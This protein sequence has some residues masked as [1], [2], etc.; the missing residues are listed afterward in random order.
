[1]S[2]AHTQHR[3]IGRLGTHKLFSGNQPLLNQQLRQCVGLRETGDEK[4][5]QCDRLSI[6]FCHCAS[7][8]DHFIRSHQHVGRD[9]QADLL[10][11]LQVDHKLELRRLLYGKVGG[12][13]AF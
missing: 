11:C 5:F 2:Y 12:L 8:L 6:W 3:L 4:V 7:S 13:G 9:R 10:R 1:M